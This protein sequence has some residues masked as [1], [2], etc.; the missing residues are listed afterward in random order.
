MKFSI[1]CFVAIF[2][3]VMTVDYGLQGARHDAW[4]HEQCAAKNKKQS[5]A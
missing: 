3:K 5:E 2:T 1:V 4:Q